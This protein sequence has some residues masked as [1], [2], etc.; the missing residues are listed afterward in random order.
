MSVKIKYTK[1]KVI[2]EDE[3]V[4][5]Q[6]PNLA[7]E[8]TIIRK[9]SEPKKSGLAGKLQEK[10]AELKSDKPKEEKKEEAPKKEAPKKETPKAEDKKEAKPKAAPK[11][12]TKQTK[13]AQQ[14]RSY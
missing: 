3:F 6:L 4:R 7:F 13:S 10:V 9:K 12:G 11:P 14:V 1:T 8:K 2:K 5:V